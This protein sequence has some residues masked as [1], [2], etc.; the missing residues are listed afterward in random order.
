VTPERSACLD[1]IAGLIFA[2]ESPHPLRVAIDGPDCAGQE[3]LTD[4]LIPILER[5]GRQVIKATI[6][7]FHRPKVERAARGAESPEGYFLD[8]FQYPALRDVLLKPLGPGG[9][10]QFRR[11]AFDF[12]TDGPV[13][14]PVETA[15]PDAILL[16]EG[17]FLLRAELMDC[18]DFG[19]WLDITPAEVLVRGIRRNTP[20]QGEEKA[21]RVFTVRYIP[22]Q[23]LFAKRDNPKDHAN[24]VVDNEDPD[25]PR[26]VA[27]HSEG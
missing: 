10:R 18:W 24:V 17:I 5:S 1:T 7:G 9:S 26:L 27:R 22:G 2:I 12:R 4:D 21:K 13:D 11:A 25:Q 15:A 14:S 3:A 20:F 23:E 6:D 16:F 19:I 8:S